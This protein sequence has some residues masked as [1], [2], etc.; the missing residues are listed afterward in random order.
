[1]VEFFFAPFAPFHGFP[2]PLQI[3]CGIAAQLLCSGRF[4]ETMKAIKTFSAVILTVSLL[5]APLAVFAADAPAKEAPSK[6]KPYTLATCPV[7]DEKLGEMGDPVVFEYK[8]REI[9]LCCKGC[10]KDF[11]KEPAKYI[12]KIDA[13]EKK[14]AEATDK[15]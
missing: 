4:K 11:D 8:G 10:R 12:K 15:K 14:A 1:V 5:S 3:L 2:R 9:K 7:S 6:A 13:A